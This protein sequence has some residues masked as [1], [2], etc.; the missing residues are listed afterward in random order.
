VTV[1]VP[2][3]IRPPWAVLKERLESEADALANA[4]DAAA[5][6]PVATVAIAAADKAASR[7]KVR[8]ETAD[9]GRR[10]MGWDMADGEAGFGVVARCL[11]QTQSKLT[12]GR[13]EDLRLLSFVNNHRM[14]TGLP[15]RRSLI[16]LPV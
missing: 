9:N 16:A 3:G 5:V 11:G 7:K 13:R 8:R 15:S 4:G 6:R 10:F 14:E 12:S 2:G 1:S